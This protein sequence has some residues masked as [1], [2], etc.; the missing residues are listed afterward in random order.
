M[1]VSTAFSPLAAPPAHDFYRDLRFPTLFEAAAIGIALCHLDGRILEG[2]SALALLL[3][4][5]QAE[6]AGL[7]PWRFYEGDSSESAHLLPDLLHGARASFAVEK[8]C[9]RKDAFAF[10]GRLTVSLARNAQHDPAFLIVL[11]E[12]ATERTRIQQQLR[13]AEKMEII[14]RLTA[15]VAHDFNNLLTG[16]LLYCDLL[17]SKLDPTDPLRRH[18]EEIQ[19]AGEQGS[20]LTQQLLSFARKQAP[21]PRPVPIN[22]IVSSTENLLRR[23][24]GEHIELIVALDPAAGAVFADPAQLR[25]VLLNLALNARD[26][27]RPGGKIRVQTRTAEFPANPGSASPR[28]AVCIAV[29]D[30]G[31]G[32]DAETRTHLFEPFFTTKRPGEGTGMGLATVHR[33][34]TE[35]GGRI[36][37]LTHPA[38]GTRVEI[39]FPMREAMCESPICE[40]TMRESPMCETTS[41][42]R[43]E[44][45]PLPAPLEANALFSSAPPARASE[46]SAYAEGRSSTSN[47]GD[48]VGADPRFLQSAADPIT[49]SPDIQAIQPASLNGDQP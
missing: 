30:N 36:K 49:R 23:L 12:D 9:H 17:L 10:W 14:G 19:Q 31:C 8:S 3:G 26:A 5:E 45:E 47:A 43:R 39:F 37:V 24:I 22:L 35:A 7:D 25:Q 1:E 2:N 15:G 6:L 46:V 32:M 16:F 28:P 44:T 34:V 13:Q 33:I 48:P 29:E 21:N 40:L 38:Q 11:L 41:E 20:A 4:Y 27:L 42:P 18:V